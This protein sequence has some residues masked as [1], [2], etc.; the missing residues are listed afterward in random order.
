MLGF[1][2]SWLTVWGASCFERWCADGVGA[3]ERKGT[4]GTGKE[5]KG[6]G[7]EGK[8]RERKGKEGKGR[9]RTGKEGKERE[10]IRCSPRTRMLTRMS[11]ICS[12]AEHFSAIVYLRRGDT[13]GRCVAGGRG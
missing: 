1:S 8:G 10:R 7:K 5:R 13:K 12:H 2:F 3:R 6:N 9:E 11:W 4:E